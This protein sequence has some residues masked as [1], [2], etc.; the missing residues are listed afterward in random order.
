MAS[1]VATDASIIEKELQM[2]SQIIDAERDYG[3]TLDNSTETRILDEFKECNEDISAVGLALLE[4]FVD[5]TSLEERI[6]VIKARHTHHIIAEHNDLG[7]PRFSDQ[8]SR[9]AELAQRLDV[10][11]DYTNAFSLFKS[12]KRDYGHLTQSLNQLLNKQ[13]EIKLG[14]ESIKPVHSAGT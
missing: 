5:L 1:A 11:K 8:E 4:R 13:R 6:E 12:V 10:D 14:V 9:E 7:K 3:S 2:Q